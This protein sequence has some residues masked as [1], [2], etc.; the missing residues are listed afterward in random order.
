MICLCFVSLGLSFRIS[1]YY[2][3]LDVIARFVKP[4]Q[5]KQNDSTKAYH[6]HRLD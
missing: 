5:I 6:D 2:L 4:S 1:R 3:D